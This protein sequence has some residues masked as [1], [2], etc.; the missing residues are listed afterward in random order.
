V[1]LALCGTLISYEIDHPRTLGITFTLVALFAPFFLMRLSRVPVYFIAAYAALVP[2]NDVLV[3]GTGTMFMRLLG[4]ATAGC[5]LFS[6]AGTQHV[7]KPSRSVMC[8]I[9]LTLYAGASIFW[10]ID[11]TVALA[12][13]TS[14]LSYVAFFVVLCL[15]PVDLGAMKVILA[16]AVLGGLVAAAFGDVLFLQGA[17]HAVTRI[18]IR[19]GSHET[20]YNLF[21]TALIMPMA[22]VLMLFLRSHVFLVK[23]VWFAGLMLFLYGF[24]STSSRGAAIAFGAMVIFLAL[25][26]PYRKQLLFI[27][28]I[29]AIVIL[30]SPLTQRFMAADFASADLR[31]DIWKVGLAAFRRY[32]IAGAGTG[33]FEAAFAQYYLSTP[34]APLFWGAAPHS[35]LIRSAV[36]W[37]IPGVALVG[38]L[39]FFVFREL[40]HV[41]AAGLTADICLALRA[42]ILGLLVSAFSLDLW[43]IKYAWL[44]FALAVMMRTA[45]HVQ[46]I[47]VEDASSKRA[48]R[49]FTRSSV[50]SADW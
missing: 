11:P 50:L 2:F 48:G 9:A 27:G 28:T 7:V 42:G 10:A 39:W 40:A 22:L 37:G 49:D 8:A 19:N 26:A 16:G 4:V 24:V 5:I 13:Y 17:A 34:H 30:S 3:T 14:F 25:R 46:G 41:K 29:A 1:W 18:E 45:L 44:A 36:E 43:M 20:D 12:A 21:A 23:A 38:A 32:W 15:Y 47:A 35:E 6:I 31:V 33:N